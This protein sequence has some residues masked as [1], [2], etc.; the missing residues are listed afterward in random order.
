VEAPLVRATQLAPCCLRNPR[1]P[2][3]QAHRRGPP[4]LKEEFR[5]RAP[6]KVPGAGTDRF[7]AHLQSADPAA[8]QLL[9]L[10]S[11]KSRGILI[12][13]GE[14]VDFRALG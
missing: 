10:C 3:S 4:L 5:G 12:M 9:G 13:L 14:A 2:R 11:E 8:E 1:V 7:P 6:W